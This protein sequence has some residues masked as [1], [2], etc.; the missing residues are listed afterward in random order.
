MEQER[1]LQLCIR[2]EIWNWDSN[3]KS[4]VKYY[5]LMPIII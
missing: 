1:A 5:F 2:R 4:C 3:P